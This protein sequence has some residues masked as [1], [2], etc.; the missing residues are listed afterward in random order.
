MHRSHDLHQVYR[1][2]QAIGFRHADEVYRCWQAREFPRA[3]WDE[4]G[5]EGVFA[6]ATRRGSGIP[7]GMPWLAAAMEGVTNAT[8]DGGFMIS[9]AVHGV[10]GLGII[11]RCAPEPV[12]ECYLD[13]LCDGS[14]I[15]AFAV[16]EHHGGTDALNPRTRVTCGEETAR[17]T[18][19]KWHITNA[20]I[21]SVILALARDDRGRLV[22]ALIDRDLDGVSVGAAL[23]P[24]GARTSPVAEITF[25]DVL[26]PARQVFRPY[27]E[28]RNVL[29]EVLTAEKIL[30]A[31]PAIGMMER[32]IQE[33]MTFARGR[34][35]S[36]R[37][38]TSQQYV[39]HRLTEMQIALETVRGFAHATLQRFVRGDDVTL[40]AS[41]LKLQA[42]RLGVE[43]GI[44]AIQACGSYGLQETSRLPMAML[45]GLAGTIGG[46]TEEAQ[47]LIVFTEM[48]RQRR[49]MGSPS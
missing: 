33:S 7:N 42:M 6:A 43:T 13:C 29:R 35:T 16:T 32:V 39:Q 3:L 47:R 14:E 12:R 30:G 45:D 28:G 20:P 37:T 38:L 36:D 5:A 34:S 18:G 26:V 9:V 1:H 2:F 11:D 8:L 21:A 15:L 24:A 44:N 48:V 4:L 41:A 19:R 46:G 23:C 31:F 49:R 10:F 27:H 40:E 25:E 22:T 17:V